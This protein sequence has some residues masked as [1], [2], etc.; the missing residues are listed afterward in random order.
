MRSLAGMN[1][2]EFKPLPRLPRADGE[3]EMAELW[4][5][6]GDT[7]P[8]RTVSGEHSCHSY[9][10]LLSRMAWHFP[11]CSATASFHFLVL[12]GCFPEVTVV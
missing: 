11:A 6:Q 8:A 12:P 7:S 9:T 3:L 5:D 2:S 1:K 10:P 4:K